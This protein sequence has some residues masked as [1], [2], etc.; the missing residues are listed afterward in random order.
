MRDNVSYKEAE[1][2]AEVESVTVLLRTGGLEKEV[3]TFLLK[4]Q[5]QS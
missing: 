2:P 1:D 3:A 5:S 4:D